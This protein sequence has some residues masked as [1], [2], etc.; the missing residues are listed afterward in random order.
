MNGSRKTE[1]RSAAFGARR[2]DR[3]GVLILVVLSL[4]IMF[5]VVAVMYVAVATRARSVATNYSSFERTG[6]TPE[7]MVES[8]ARDLLRGSANPHSPLRSTS[9]LDDMYGA[10]VRGTVQVVGQAIPCAARH[11]LRKEPSSALPPVPGCP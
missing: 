9:L 7:Q 5:V 11:D 6:D 1:Q 8:L 3:R 2:K 10:Y 4:L